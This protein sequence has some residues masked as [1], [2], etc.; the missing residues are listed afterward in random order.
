ML[1][2]IEI[3]FKKAAQRN[4]LD[5]VWQGGV[6]VKAEAYTDSPTSGVSSSISQTS[7]PPSS[8]FAIE[9]GRNKTEK[10]NA[11]KRYQDFQKWMWKECFHSLNL[12]ATKY[13]KQRCAPIL[14]V[15]G[16]C[17]DSYIFEDNHCPSCHRTFGNSRYLEHAAQCEENPDWTSFTL[18]SSYILRIRLLK[19]SLANIEVFFVTVN[20]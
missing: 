10:N 3:S 11:L 19:S 7:D 16:I 6:T 20:L 15:C 5:T 1:Q 9:L 17:H 4:R 12:C 18:E 14:S 2:K 13:G 8:S